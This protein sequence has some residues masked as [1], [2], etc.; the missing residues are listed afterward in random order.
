MGDGIQLTDE[1]G[2]APA[3]TQE[4]IETQVRFLLERLHMHPDTE[5][6]ITFVDERRMSDLHEEYMDEPGPTDVMA[7]PMDELQPGAP[8][9]LSGPGVLGDV[10]ICPQF[11]ARQA[12]AA[13]HDLAQEM[14]L[15]LTHGILHLLGHDH[16]EPE[17]HAVMFGLQDDLLAQW[18]AVRGT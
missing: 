12:Q 13:G 8:G 15:L 9:A 10:V 4:S 14:Q 6:S 11:A 16:A 18:R 2:C 1:S 5:V 3:W 17:E 7:W